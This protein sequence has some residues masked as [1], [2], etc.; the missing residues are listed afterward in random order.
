MPLTNTGRQNVKDLYSLKIAAGEPISL[1]TF[2]SLYL[3]SIA[4]NTGDQALKM[5]S[6]FF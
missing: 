1:L 3:D 4:D 2:S 6:Y 5:F